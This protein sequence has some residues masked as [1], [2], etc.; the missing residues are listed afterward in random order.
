MRVQEK[1]AGIV[2]GSTTCELPAA[3]PERRWRVVPR[4]L[5]VSHETELACSLPG[6]AGRRLADVTAGPREALVQYLG[7]LSTAYS[8]GIGL[9]CVGGRGS[10]KTSALGLIAEAYRWAPQP[11][12]GVYYRSMM[13]LAAHCNAYTHSADADEQYQRET[14]LLRT[15]GVLLIDEFSVL[16]L[17][18]KGAVQWYALLD[19]RLSSDAV[20]CIA[21]NVDLATLERIADGSGDTNMLRVVDRMRPRLQVVR[22]PGRSRREALAEEWWQ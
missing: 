8:R 2:A 6:L 22:F 1:R 7:H 3:L 20:T 5:A 19:W 11:G 13:D 21:S 12:I 16:H 14:R 18:E 15:C 4:S 9:L 17:T 10:G